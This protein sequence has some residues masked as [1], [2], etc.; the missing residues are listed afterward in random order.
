MAIINCP[1][2]NKRI[3]SAATSCQY[4]KIKFNDDIDEEQ[5][6]RKASNVRFMK[7]QRLQN[8]SFLFVMLFATGAMV[9]YFGITDAND[10]LNFAGRLLLGLGF[11][12]Y[13]VS[14]VLLVM[15]RKK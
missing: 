2:C 4:C 12:G 6:I 9:M 7:L 1:G 3:S 14:R 5:Q 11:I 15:S 8:F 10:N 13:V